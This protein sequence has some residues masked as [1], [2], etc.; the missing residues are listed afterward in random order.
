VLS[1]VA[2]GPRSTG[3]SRQ[4]SESAA[5][6][7]LSAVGALEFA[8][9]KPQALS[10]GQAQRVALARALAAEPAVILLDE[11]LSALDVAVAPGVRQVLRRVL[12]NGGRT[13]LIVTHD[14]LDAL[15]L[16]D[17]AIVI[18]AGHIVEDGPV[19]EVL[20]RPRSAFAARIA[21]V[22]LINGFVV[23]H[24]LRTMDGGSVAGLVDAECVAGEPAV[25]V[26]R[27]SAVAVHVAPP[28]GSPRNHFAVTV[29]E[30]EPRGEVIRVRAADTIHGAAGLVADL[31]A[32]AVADL[33]LAPGGDVYFAVKAT[34]V[35]I[36]PAASDPSEPCTRSAF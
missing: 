27:P 16:A 7:W 3:S 1:N 23:A 14:I 32:A 5:R 26:F 34:E 36:Y 4:D 20:S 18:E 17:R 13:A 25:A 9:R 30:L 33:D 21:G 11:P 22:N 10:G 35:S 19:R 2:F 6:Q 15:A 29:A 12:R 8:D 28:S 31:T 24:G